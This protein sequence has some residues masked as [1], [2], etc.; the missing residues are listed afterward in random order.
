MAS[1]IPN[2]LNDD[3]LSVLRNISRK[4]IP[5][6]VIDPRMAKR[7]LKGHA[8]NSIMLK[9]NSLT[10]NVTATEHLVATANG[11]KLLAGKNT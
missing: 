6:S 11:L 9:G 1:L 8:V 4:P 10:L 3:A 7:L 2:V 5:R